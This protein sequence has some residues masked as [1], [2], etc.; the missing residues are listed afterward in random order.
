MLEILQTRKKRIR[1]KRIDLEGQFVYSTQEVLDIIQSHD[2]AP[3][4]KRRR[5]RP[6]KT[7]II[8]SGDEEDQESIADLLADSESELEETVARRTRSHRIN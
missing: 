5:G 2:S 7:P 3:A 1:G 6:R 4:P 8:E